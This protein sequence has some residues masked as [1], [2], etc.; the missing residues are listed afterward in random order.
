[1]WLLHAF[2]ALYCM[3]SRQFL[4]FNA[5][6]NPNQIASAHCADRMELDSASFLFV[7]TVAVSMHGR[8]ELMI[9]R[10]LGLQFCV[11][12]QRCMLQGHHFSS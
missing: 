7:K 4:L 2:S 8:I 9:M 10:H 12:V 5:S 3:Y 6:F 11:Y 1:M